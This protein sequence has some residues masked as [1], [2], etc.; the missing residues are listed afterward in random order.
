MTLGKCINALKDGKMIPYRESK[1]TRSIT[2][3]FTDSYKVYMIAH[4]NRNLEMFHENVKV[5]E[6]AAVSTKIKTINLGVN[7][8]IVKSARKRF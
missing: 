4:I 1:L 3:Y 7:P 5:L 8:S 6:Y 2:E